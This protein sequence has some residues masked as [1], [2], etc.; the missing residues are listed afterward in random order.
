M[1]TYHYTEPEGQDGRGRT[2]EVPST[3]DKGRLEQMKV[4]SMKS[5]KFHFFPG[6]LELTS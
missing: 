2:Y 4:G 1:Q 6:Q 3:A 5:G